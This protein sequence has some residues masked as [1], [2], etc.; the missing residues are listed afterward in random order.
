LRVM[1]A[2]HDW[3]RANG[4]TSAALNTSVDGRALYESM[5]Y[6]VTPSPMMF[7]LIVGV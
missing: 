5:G 7:C 6:V 4:V 2:I 3:C 1:E